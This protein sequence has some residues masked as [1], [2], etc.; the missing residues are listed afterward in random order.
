MKKLKLG[1]I[2]TGRIGKVHIATLVQSVPQAEVV[3]IADID[4]KSAKE[5]AAGF[6]ISSVYTNYMDV[7]KH[8]DVE[9]VAICSRQIPMPGT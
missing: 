8:P 7:I 5:V 1:V 9:A 6:G 4:L 3:A 2:G